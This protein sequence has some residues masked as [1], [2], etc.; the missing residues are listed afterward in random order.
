MQCD[1][2][3][4]YKPCIS[5]CK[6]KTCDNLHEFRNPSQPCHEEPC[7]EGCAPEQCERGKVYESDQNL[8]V[9][10]IFSKIYI[11]NHCFKCI[12][13]LDCKMKCLYEDGVQYYEGDIMEESLHRSW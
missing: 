9:K 11:I 4:S 10:H 7:V 6:P 13:S 1:R 8:Q 3:T 5:T 12:N 2:G